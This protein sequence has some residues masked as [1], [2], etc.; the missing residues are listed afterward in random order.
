M[1][2]VDTKDR[3][4]SIRIECDPCRPF[5]VAT[6]NTT[7]AVRDLRVRLLTEDEKRAAAKK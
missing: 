3:R 4:I 5:G 1:V 6:Y 2:D 7:G